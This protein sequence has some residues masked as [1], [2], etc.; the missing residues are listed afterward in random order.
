MNK[1]VRIRQHSV[2]RSSLECV[3]PVP[4]PVP[5]RQCKHLLSTI[6]QNASEHLCFSPAAVAWVEEDSMPYDSFPTL[7]DWPREEEEW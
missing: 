7:R 5:G 2:V 3:V 6:M 1:R 4:V